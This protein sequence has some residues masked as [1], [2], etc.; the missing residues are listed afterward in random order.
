MDNEVILALVT[1]ILGVIMFRI[2]AGGKIPLLSPIARFIWNLS[3][4]ICSFIPFIGWIGAK[5]MIVKTK[6]EAT[7]QVDAM[8]IS[9]QSDKMGAELA[10]Q[11]VTRSKEEQR[12][13]EEKAE[14]ER[15]ISRETGETAHVHGSTVDIGNKTFDL[16][17]VK[18]E[19]KL[20]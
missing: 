14:L 2:V 11:C 8:K 1:T 5:L 15:R 4:T 6:T 19:L 13:V 16:N 7:A 9:E 17:D 12:R 18:N 3:C 20:Q 10:A